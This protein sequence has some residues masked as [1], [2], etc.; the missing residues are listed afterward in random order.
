M[1]AGITLY[2]FLNIQG[3]V[4]V[5]FSADGEAN[6]TMDKI[7]GLLLLPVISLAVFLLLNYLPRIDPL[8][9]N[10]KDFESALKWM[11]VALVAF[12]AYVQGLIVAWNLEFIVDIS[13][14]MV[15]AVAGV[16]YATGLLLKRAE[17]NWFIGIRTPW[18]LSSEEVWKKTHERASP[19]F[20]FAAVF[21]LGAL[22]YP[23][24]LLE[25]T[26]IPAV[27]VAGYSTLYSFI[28][29]RELEEDQ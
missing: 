13:R 9:E 22:A 15:P 29:Y 5:H 24:M 12:M 4:A 3:D 2:G 10:V 1:I 18:T 21:S 25:F 28:K 26:V 16:F 7:Q 23:D 27:I 14:A 17:R 20:R 19:L 6:S 8:G 11:A